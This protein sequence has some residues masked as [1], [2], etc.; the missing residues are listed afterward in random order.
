MSLRENKN[1][2]LSYVLK[3][4]PPSLL[5]RLRQRG[6]RSTPPPGPSPFSRR[7]ERE[8]GEEDEKLRLWWEFGWRYAAVV[9]CFVSGLC[10]FSSFFS[11]FSLSGLTWKGKKAKEDVRLW[12]VEERKVTKTRERT[13]CVKGETTDRM[14][15]ISRYKGVPAD[16]KESHPHRGGDKRRKDCVTNRRR[17]GVERKGRRKG[18]VETKSVSRKKD[19]MTVTAFRLHNKETCDSVESASAGLPSDKTP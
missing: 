6:L 9:F 18:R 15:H 14:A 10:P 16:E 11:L 13:L 8:R 17:E 7:R 1:A 19:E 3:D 2:I 12:E 4:N 5:L